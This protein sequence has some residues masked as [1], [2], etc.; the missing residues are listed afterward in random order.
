MKHY[1]GAT[2]VEL[3]VSIVILSVSAVGVMV[4][5]TQTTSKSANP[6]IRAQGTAIA[7]AY[8]EEIMSQPLTD[9]SGVD[10]GG[11]EPGESNNRASFDDVTDYFDVD[12]DDGARDQNGALIPG[13]EGYNVTV[14]V[15]ATTLNGSAAR[16][17]VV[18]VTYDGIAQF[19][20]PVTAYRL[21][22]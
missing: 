10:T 15:T 11:R 14:A 7:Q 2:L 18:N 16:R 1:K 4:V 5:I 8:M 6:M 20:L 9:P 22:Q 12:D 21:L 17:I 19:S 3:I 13:L